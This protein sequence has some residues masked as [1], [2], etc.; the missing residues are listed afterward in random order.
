M[1]FANDAAAAPSVMPGR[2][3]KF[4]G[5]RYTDVN[6]QPILCDQCGRPATSFL[7]LT[8]EYPGGKSEQQDRCWLHS[9]AGLDSIL[10]RESADLE[11]LRQAI[12]A[13]LRKRGK[14]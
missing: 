1:G 12:T 11:V 3:M 4:D 2:M 5:E 10:S 8:P 7:T 9:M 14:E 6:G 13:E